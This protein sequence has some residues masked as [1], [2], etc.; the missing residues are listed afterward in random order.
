MK[1]NNT[2]LRILQN[3]P[4]QY[5]VTELYVNYNTFS[6]PDLYTQRI[7]LLV[8]NFVYHKD[9]L[10]EILMRYI[11]YNT[12]SAANIHLPRVDTGYGQRSV[13]YVR[14]SLWNGLPSSWR[15]AISPSIPP[16]RF[17]A[18]TICPLP[19]REHLSPVFPC[20]SGSDGSM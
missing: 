7:L 12:R 16:L 2:L 10:P 19:A 11:N 5:H 17:V 14:V 15:G 4:R 13:C 9:K 8:H 18:K 6:V 20:P 3:Q 1:L